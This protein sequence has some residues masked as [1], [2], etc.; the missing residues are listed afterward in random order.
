M[1]GTGETDRKVESEIVTEK[2]RNP[3]THR[4]VKRQTP[5]TAPSAGDLTAEA[6]PEGAWPRGG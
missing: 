2:H 6:G 3:E 1:R 5:Q 4:R